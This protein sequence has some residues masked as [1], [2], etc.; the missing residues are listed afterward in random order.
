MSGT[1]SRP[2]VAS[3]RRPS[4]ASARQEPGQVAT[5]KERL[6][7]D[8]RAATK[9]QDA[10]RRDTLRLILA[11][12][13]NVEVEKQSAALGDAD[14]VA[15]L[16]RQAKMRHEAIESMASRPDI[17]ARERSELAVIEAY[18][19]TQLSRD[20]IAER[21]RAAIAAVGATSSREQGKV[22]QKL[23]PELKGQADGKLVAEVVGELL[24]KGGA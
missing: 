11:G 12:V 19:P 3:A 23:M 18:L 4:A 15:V 6:E 5:L 13:H 1:R 21:A 24:A 8:L 22:M 9:A 20:A 10:T 7:Q 14:V 17:V 2:H 16:R